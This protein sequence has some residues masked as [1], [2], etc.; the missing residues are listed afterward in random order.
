MNAIGFLVDEI[1]F[2]GYRKV[3]IVKPVFIIGAPRSGTT[4][5]HRTL[6]KHPAFTTT[7]AIDCLLTPSVSQ[8]KLLRCLCKIDGF[9]GRPFGRLISTVQTPLLKKVSG[10]HAFS[11]TDAEEDFLFLT[12]ILQC[13]LLVIAYPHSRWLWR[14]SCADRSAD[15]IGN[16][17]TMKWYRLCLRKHLY[18]NPQASRYLSKN[19]SFSGMAHL[20]AETF[21][22]CQ[23][24]VCERDA[25]TAVRSQFRVLQPIRKMFT[26]DANDVRFNKQL[27]KTLKFYY[28]NLHALKSNLPADR[29]RSVPLWQVSQSPVTTFQSLIEWIDQ[30][31]PTSESI[32]LSILN[33]LEANQTKHPPKTG[34]YRAAEEVEA[35][36]SDFLPWQA[37]EEFAL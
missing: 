4:Y 9:I 31:H 21:P 24:I 16:K 17:I 10:N 33:D 2:R 20:L 3:D 37:S 6:A 27:L 22:D 13:F 34:S 15:N 29:V 18:C 14:Q 7:T 35:A 11:L 30:F 23:M 26:A 19:P 32:S 28:K 5:V 12:P 1:F 36:I 25:P 8:R